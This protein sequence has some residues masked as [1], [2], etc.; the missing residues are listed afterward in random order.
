MTD[1]DIEA[2]KQKVFEEIGS[3]REE[4]EKRLQELYGWDF[5]TFFNKVVLSTIYQQKVREQFTQDEDTK[6]QAEKEA[7]EVLKMVQ[8][9]EKSFQDI[10]KEY[11]DDPTFAQLGGDWGWVTKG[12]LPQEVEEAA[13]S[14]EKG[15]VSDLIETE[16]GYHIIRIEDKKEDGSEVWLYDIFIQYP[17]F[18]QYLLDYLADSNVYK[19][20]K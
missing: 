18:E 15:D 19:L 20:V 16:I 5:D 4:I 1:E 13:F 7:R 12:L 6:K 11:S 3:S 14:M 10:A 2:E 17:D 9:G 8:K